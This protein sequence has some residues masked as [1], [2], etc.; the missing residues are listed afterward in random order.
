MSDSDGTSDEAGP[1]PR[2]PIREVKAMKDAIRAMKGHLTRHINSATKAIDEA[3]SRPSSHV[4]EVLAELLGKIRSQMEALEEKYLQLMA[5]DEEHYADREVK[6][7]SEADRADAA[8][9]R[10]L[11]ALEGWPGQ[12]VTEAWHISGNDRN[13]TRQGQAEQG[14]GAPCLVS[15]PQHGGDE[16]V[17]QEIQGVVHE[18]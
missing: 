12:P 3:G 10:I 1:V 16:V 2:V 11:R 14:F 13:Q 6:L 18:L 7:N 5:A 8:V 9:N 4:M 15:R 17:V